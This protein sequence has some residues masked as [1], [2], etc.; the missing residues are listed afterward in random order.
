MLY[1]LG[2]SR[3]SCEQSALGAIKDM[4]TPFENESVKSLFLLPLQQCMKAS[5]AGG[6]YQTQ[7]QGQ[8][9]VELSRL[10][11]KPGNTEQEDPGVG[12]K[13]GWDWRKTT[14]LQVPRRQVQGLWLCGAG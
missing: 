2:A 8:V 1:R 6:W 12:E 10:Q 9:C 13:W 4:K 7:P 11:S 5:K 14:G 3:W